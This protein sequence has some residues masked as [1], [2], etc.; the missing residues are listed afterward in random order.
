MT[1]ARCGV[2]LDSASGRVSYSAMRYFRAPAILSL[3][4][5]A[6]ACGSPA[7]TETASAAA[8]SLAS[9]ASPVTITFAANW[10]DS[11][12]QPLVAGDA[13]TIAYDPARLPSCRGDLPTGP[14]WSIT[15]FYQVNGGTVG[16]VTVAGQGLSNYSPPATF[17]LPGI[18][19]DLAMWF[20]VTSA[21]GCE[22]YD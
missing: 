22:A 7:P 14:G 10:T 11:A 15:A 4:L 2:L 3:F 9:S 18:S 20:Q 13:V 16:T 12:S 8:S 5:F 21:W 6:T 19:G 1:G 17:T